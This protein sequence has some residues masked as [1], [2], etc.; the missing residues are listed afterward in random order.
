MFHTQSEARR[1]FVDRIIQQADTEQV[2]L[3]DDERQMLLWS[4]ST[5]DS[6]ADPELV[7]RLSAEVS[8]ADYESKIAGLVQRSFAADVA[9]EQQ[10]KERWRQ[11]WS[12]LNQGDH[13]ILIMINEAI[14]KHVKPWW[15]F[16]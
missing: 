6:V 1:F 4:E 15:Q 5:P 3:S 10:A 16:W 9:V 14:G 8:D 2:E 13:Y 12:V 11:A 7:E